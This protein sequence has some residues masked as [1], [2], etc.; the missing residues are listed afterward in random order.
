MVGIAQSDQLFDIQQRSHQ[1]LSASR[2]R[3]ASSFVRKT[4]CAGS[5]SIPSMV[6]FLKP[7]GLKNLKHSFLML[8][9]IN[10]HGIKPFT[11]D[12]YSPPPPPPPPAS[13]KRTQHRGTVPAPHRFGH[14]EQS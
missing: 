2:K 5:G 9:C 3:S 8:S 1:M 12:R 7:A 13:P 4:L 14:G 6:N 10:N 11:L